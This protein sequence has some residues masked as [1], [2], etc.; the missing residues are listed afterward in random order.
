MR[1]YRKVGTT[2]RAT[3]HAFSGGDPTMRCAHSR[4]IGLLIGAPGATHLRRR[5]SAAGDNSSPEPIRRLSR[6]TGEGS[7]GSDLWFTAAV[8]RPRHICANCA[9]SN[10]SL[11]RILERKCTQPKGCSCS[12]ARPPYRLA[13]QVPLRHQSSRSKFSRRKSSDDPTTSPASRAVSG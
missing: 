1:A 9:I 4:K 2:C 3:I 13:G 7:G 11:T 12:P 5:E 10:G 6:G 8:R